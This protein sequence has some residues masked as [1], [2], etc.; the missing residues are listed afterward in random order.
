[1]K[2]YHLE[3]GFCIFSCYCFT[4][5]PISKPLSVLVEMHGEKFVLTVDLDIYLVGTFDTPL[6]IRCVEMLIS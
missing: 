6:D 1:M 2:V 5:A 3:F 4:F